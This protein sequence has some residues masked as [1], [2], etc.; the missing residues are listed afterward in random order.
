MRPVNNIVAM[1]GGGLFDFSA[2][3]G[4]NIQ[5]MMPGGGLLSPMPSNAPV[6]AAPPQVFAPS[7]IYPDAI[8]RAAQQQNNAPSAAATS[9]GAT[10]PSMTLPVPKPPRPAPQSAPSYPPAFYMSPQARAMSADQY[11]SLLGQTPAAPAAAAEEPQKG[12]FS[13]FFGTSFD[14]PRTRRNLAGAAAL[15]QA[16]GPQLKPVGTGQAIGMGIEAMLGQQSEIDKLNKVSAKGFEARGPI[17]RKG[18]N[19]YLGEGVFNPTTGQMMLSTPGGEIIP[20]PADA[21]PT[22]KSAL[23]GERLS[24]NQMVKLA[25]DVRQ[26]ENSLRKLQK[27]LGTQGGT[28]QGFQRLGDTFL[29]RLKTFFGGDLDADELNLAIANGQMQ[30]ILGGL[31]VATVGPGVMTEQDAERVVAAIGGRPDALQNPAVMGRLIQD[32]FEFQYNLYEQQYDD[33][34]LA[35]DF[36]GR[37]MRDK[38]LNPFD[39]QGSVPSSE[40]NVGFTIL[41]DEGNS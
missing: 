7:P 41:P 8:I 6:V 2:R 29:T 27:Y 40:G 10:P 31:R 34:S 1:P 23:S 18:T 26:S 33:L 32:A 36:Y 20:L 21:E 16:G 11:Q 5:P 4:A 28:N 38:I 25:G 15:L 24:G 3:P 12:L 30:A 14:D 9:S 22:V 35:Y 19:E 37:P 39:D 13:D 17:V